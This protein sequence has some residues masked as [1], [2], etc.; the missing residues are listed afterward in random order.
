MTAKNCDNSSKQN[1]TILW[2]NIWHCL[3]RYSIIKQISL[4]AIYKKLFCIN[5][6]TDFNLFYQI[7][8]F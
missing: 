2:N 6:W 7:T 4:I 1:E 5:S 3:R 8:E